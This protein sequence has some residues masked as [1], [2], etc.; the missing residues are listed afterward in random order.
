MKKEYK[1]PL[2]EIVF[3]NTDEILQEGTVTDSEGDIRGDDDTILGNEGTF[4]EE[5]GFRAS[6]S[7]WD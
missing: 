6:K 3:L 1:K 7:L 5:E 2:T 4:D